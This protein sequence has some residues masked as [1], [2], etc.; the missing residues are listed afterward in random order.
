M[1]EPIRPA[2]RTPTLRIAM[3]LA[4]LLRLPFADR[5]GLRRL[6]DVAAEIVQAELARERRP[7]QRDQRRVGRR[8]DPALPDP[9]FHGLAAEAALVERGQHR[10]QVAGPLR[11]ELAQELV[12]G[13]RPHGELEDALGPGHGRPERNQ[14][15]RNCALGSLVALSTVAP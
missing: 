3:R 14:Y 8:H 10:V 6:L 4:L 9:V 11:L 7:A 1:P 15:D 12:D 13:R 5:E 2:P